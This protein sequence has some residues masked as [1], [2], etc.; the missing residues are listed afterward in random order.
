[1]KWFKRVLPMTVTDRKKGYRSQSRRESVADWRRGKEQ[2]WSEMELSVIQDNEAAC[3]HGVVTLYSSDTS[4]LYYCLTSYSK[5]TT[6]ILHA[7]TCSHKQSQV[8]HDTHMTLCFLYFYYCINTIVFSLIFLFMSWI[9]P[10]IA[11]LC[12]SFITWLMFWLQCH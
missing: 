5:P 6:V 12:L 3:M 8:L 2:Q 9:F 1:M 4:G 7:H 11:W 10:Y